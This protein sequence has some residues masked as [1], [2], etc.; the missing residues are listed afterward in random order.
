ME[1]LDDLL[2]R[3]RESVRALAATSDASSSSSSSSSA[4][5]RAKEASRL[6]REL[7]GAV[8]VRGWGG[9]VGWLA[10]RFDR[11]FFLYLNRPRFHTVKTVRAAGGGGRGGLRLGARHGPEPAPAG[12]Y[13]LSSRMKESS[14]G[15][16]RS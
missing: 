16:T 10:H 12:A 7:E 9:W 1:A 3:A 14:D 11:L 8:E 6:L 13:T 2:A 5:S 4:C 15:P